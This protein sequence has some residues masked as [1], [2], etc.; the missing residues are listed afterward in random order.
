MIQFNILSG[1]RAGTARVARRFPFRI[2]RSAACDLAFDE[3]GVWDKHLELEFHAGEGIRLHSLSDALASVNGQRIT[4][5][6]LR[7]GDLI[8]IGSLR[9]RFS[10]SPAR[11]HGLRLREILTWLALVLVSLGQVGLIYWLLEP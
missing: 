10:L 2:G 8:E 1:K 3:E 4:Q 5:S 6:V 9:L 7:N 11:P